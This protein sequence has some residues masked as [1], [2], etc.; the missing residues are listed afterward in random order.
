MVSPSGI[1][2]LKTRCSRFSL[3]GCQFVFSVLS[4]L[5]RTRN[6]NREARTR[7]RERPPVLL[8]AFVFCS[9]WLLVHRVVPVDAGFGAVRVGRPLVDVAA[10]RFVVAAVVTRCDA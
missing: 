8:Q 5:K 1:R 4:S 10:Y 2:Q 3:P 7:N 9:A 6:T